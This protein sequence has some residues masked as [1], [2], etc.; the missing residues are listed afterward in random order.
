MGGCE[1]RTMK[2][3]LIRFLEHL[4]KLKYWDVERELNQEHWKGET[5]R[6]ASS[7]VFKLRNPDNELYDVLR[8]LKRLS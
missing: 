8:I 5:L 3:L 6:Y 1:K 4:L 7:K 2:S